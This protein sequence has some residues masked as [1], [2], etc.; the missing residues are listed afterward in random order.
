M[1]IQYTD[2]Y[3]DATSTLAGTYNITASNNQFSVSVDG[4]SAQVVALTTGATQTAA[5]IVT[6]LSVLT[7]CTASVVTINGNSHVRIRTTSN[8]GNSSTLLFNAPANNSNAVLGFVA[9][10]Y[11]GG[12]NVNTTFVSS[13]KQD[14]INGIETALLSAGW[15][16]ISGSTTTNLLMQSSMTPSTQNLR[17]RLRVKDNG[18]SCAVCSIENVAGTKVATNG[19]SNGGHLLPGTTKTWRVIANKHQ[20]FIFVSGGNTAREYVGFGTLYLPSW[21]AGGVI[22]EQMWLAGNSQSDTS[23]T[24]AASF[25]SHLGSRDNTG[26]SGNQQFITNNNYWEQGNTTNWNLGIM[27]LISM[28]PGNNANAAPV[29]NYRWHDASGYLTDPIMSYG[30]SA[31]TDEAMGRGQLWDCF[32]STEAY[33]VDATL[34]GID[35]RDWWNLT[36][37][38]PATASTLRGSVWVATT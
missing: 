22:Y 8:S 29:S 24:V 18:G 31:I 16:T 5:N 37:S 15:I 13:S 23:T 20:A 17:M 32:L 7:G 25:R 1:A 2:K 27:T 9:T 6:D 33:A 19:S 3:A 28:S 10:T 11:K 21:L 34:S 35:S 4:G 14:V 38:N 26:Q 30:L 12:S 36:V